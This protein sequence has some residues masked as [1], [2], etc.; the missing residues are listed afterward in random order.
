MI[1]HR[2]QIVMEI[3]Q[4]L[5]APYVLHRAGRKIVD[6]VNLVAAFEMRLGKM[7]SDEPGSACDQN[8]HFIFSPPRN[9]HSVLLRWIPK[10]R[11]KGVPFKAASFWRSWGIKLFVLE[12]AQKILGQ[13][14]IQR[15]P[16]AVHADLRSCWIQSPSIEGRNEMRALIAV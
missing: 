1:C 5:D 16:L 2:I 6:D 4:P 7:R 10:S 12:R 13:N 11:Q 9:I 8:L 15:A 14:V 3:R